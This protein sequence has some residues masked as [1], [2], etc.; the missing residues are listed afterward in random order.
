MKTGLP[1]QE[2][3]QQE[4]AL[5]A[6]LS[7]LLDEI[8]ELDEDDFKKTEIRAESATKLI[9]TPV[10]PVTKVKHQKPQ[11]NCIRFP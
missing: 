9:Q 8:P 7:R 4:L 5:D 3:V 1:K 6:Y 2:I 10:R 11:L